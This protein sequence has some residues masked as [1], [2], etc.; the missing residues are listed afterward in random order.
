MNVGGGTN[1]GLIIRKVTLTLP[2][3]LRRPMTETNAILYFYPIPA[4]GKKDSNH[5]QA[6]LNIKTYIP[7]L[8]QPSTKWRERKQVSP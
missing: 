5:K 2:C 7:F 8:L 4:A 3:S 6:I 1:R